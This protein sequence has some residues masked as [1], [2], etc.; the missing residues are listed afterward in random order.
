MTFFFRMI[1]IVARSSIDKCSHANSNQNQ[2]TILRNENENLKEKVRHDI[3]ISAIT[4]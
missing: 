1:Q 2:Y 3:I 4:I